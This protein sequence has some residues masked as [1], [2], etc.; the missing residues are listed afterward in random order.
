MTVRI[1]G[2][3]TRMELLRLRRRLALARRGH[4][5]LKDKQDELAR[6]LL[7]GFEGYLAA[8]RRLHEALRGLGELGAEARVESG[9]ADVLAATW[10]RR[11][12]GR[13]DAGSASVLSLR[14]PSFRL[15]S[16][17]WEPSHGPRQLSA[18]WDALAAAWRAAAPLLVEVAGAER[19]LRLIAA[20]LAMLRRRVS[21]LEYRLIPDLEGG[22][23]S[24]G[25]A[26]A[27]Q[28]RATLTR[29]MRVKE[30]VRG[31]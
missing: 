19:T 1:G 18:S 9:A 7:G 4:K 30:V 14:V 16:A 20:E 6:R 27:E 10:P 11:S 31:H 22:I 24:G 15:R 13:V 29:L 17:P 26:L 2:A 8:R 5:L 12:V 28:E 3:A 21:A 23:R 25:E